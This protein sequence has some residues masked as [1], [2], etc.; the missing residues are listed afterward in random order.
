MQQKL[1]ALTIG[2]SLMLAGC[3][4]FRPE[5]YSCN[6]L[7]TA[8]ADG[9]RVTL[10]TLENGKTAE[11]RL[12]G[13]SAICENK[14]DGIEVAIDTGLIVKRDKADDGEVTLAEVPVILALLDDQ[15]ALVGNETFSYRIAFDSNVS[16]VYP[17]A[18]FSVI[19]PMGGRVVMSLAPS[20][21]K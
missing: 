6:N 5:T 10:R 20:V 21:V 8:P 17:V 2:T 18:E 1:I 15:D 3:S 19:I 12:N 7:L 16:A 11:A 14:S 4:S 13:V 9:A